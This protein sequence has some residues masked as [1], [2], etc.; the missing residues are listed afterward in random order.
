MAPT[1]TTLL[2]MILILI[3]MWLGPERGIWAL[4]VSI[5][6][7]VAAAFNLPALGNASVM[8]AD[9]VAAAVAGLVLLRLL[10]VE[11]ALEAPLQPFAWWI[12]AMIVFCV[13]ITEIGRAHV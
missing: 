9:F 1:E 10:V 6:L 13:F 5:P 3:P 12:L 4:M 7:G 8:V 11:R 2:A